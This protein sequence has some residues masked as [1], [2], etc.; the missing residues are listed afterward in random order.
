MAR[1]DLRHRPRLRR[2]KAHAVRGLKFFYGGGV[3]RSI[4]FIGGLYNKVHWK[5]PNIHLIEGWAQVCWCVRPFWQDLIYIP[6][7]NT[8]ISINTLPIKNVVFLNNVQTNY[9]GRNWRYFFGTFFLI[10]YL[11]SIKN[12]GDIYSPRN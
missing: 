11:A 12:I 6:S 10:M 2:P 8:K 3:Y 7:Y 4:W 5:T 1:A 9:H